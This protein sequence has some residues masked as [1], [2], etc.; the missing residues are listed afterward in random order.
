MRLLLT[1]L[2]LL[3]LAGCTTPAPVPAPEPTRE[4]ALPVRAVEAMPSSADPAGDA[5]RV[6]ASASAPDANA[7]PAQAVEQALATDQPPEGRVTSPQAAVPPSPAATPAPPPDWVRSTRDAPLWSGPDDQALRFAVLPA[8][9]Y[10]KP[11]GPLALGRLLVAYAG[12]GGAHAPGQAWVDREVVEASGKPP[13]IT[14][15]GPDADRAAPPRRVSDSAP[16]A[17]TAASVVIVDDASG[18]ILFGSRP[19]ARLAPASI[20]KIATTIVALERGGDLERR[21]DVTVSGSAMAARDGSSIMGLEPGEQVSLRT[22][23]YGMMLPSGNDAA[24]QV[25]VTIGGSRTTY[26]DWMN[27]KVTDLGLLDTHFVTP[28]GMDASG[29]FSSAYDMAMLSRYAMHNAEFRS[30]AGAATYRGDGFSFGNLNRL[31][32]AYAGADGV[33]I[34]YT[35]RARRTMVASVTRSGHRVYVGIMR[36]DNLVGDSTTLLDWAFRT[37]SW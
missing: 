20:T 37:F 12:D 3:L 23:L 9:E 29:H 14:T 11:L 26:V 17:V 8:N 28:S 35:G 4:R 24:E 33:K 31:I 34:G 22:L 21:I 25:A 7:V 5:S 1:G 2:G 13:W 6:A 16:P 30:L 36:S 10:L 19:H 32:G 27:Q 15:A 18:E